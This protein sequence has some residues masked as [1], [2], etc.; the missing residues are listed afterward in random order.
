MAFPAADTARFPTANMFGL[1][2][3]TIPAAFYVVFHLYSDAELLR[4]RRAEVERAATLVR[5][6]RRR[7]RWGGAGG[8]QLERESCPGRG[9]RRWLPCFRRC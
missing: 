9:A 5:V 1:T 8:V 2:A 4:L 6:P 3:N 7:G